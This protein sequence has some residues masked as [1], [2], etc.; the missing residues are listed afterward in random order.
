MVSTATEASEILLSGVTRRVTLLRN[1]PFL[2]FLS[3]EE[4]IAVINDEKACQVC[5][6]AYP[7]HERLSVRLL[8]SLCCKEGC[9]MKR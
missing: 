3:E 1:V 8:R 5:G 7:T 2:R 6:D 4:K 9:M